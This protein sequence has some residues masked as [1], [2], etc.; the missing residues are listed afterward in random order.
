[1]VLR[2]ERSAEVGDL[3]TTV[4]PHQGVRGAE[5]AMGH[6]EPIVDEADPPD[7]ILHHNADVGRFQPSLSDDG[8]L[9][10]MPQGCRASLHAHRFAMHM[11]VLINR[12]L[13]GLKGPPPGF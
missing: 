13:G 8:L 6:T 7:Q 10:L 4:A 5:V 2:R 9:G 12:K 3:H 11:S 1:M